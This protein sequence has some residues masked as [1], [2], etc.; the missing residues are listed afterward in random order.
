ML[1]LQDDVSCIHEEVNLPI[2]S[3]KSYVLLK[4]QTFEPRVAERL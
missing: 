3:C 2:L 1:D 4:G